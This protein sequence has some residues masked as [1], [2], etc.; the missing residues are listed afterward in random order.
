MKFVEK[1][2][3]NMY[4]LKNEVRVSLDITVSEAHLGP[5]STLFSMMESPDVFFTKFY[6]WLDGKYL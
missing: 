2:K 1:T 5:G 4:F 3:Y 6:R